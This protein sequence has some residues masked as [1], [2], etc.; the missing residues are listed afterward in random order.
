MCSWTSSQD[1]ADS[2]RDGLFSLYWLIVW[3]L[4][5]NLWS[6]LY[7]HINRLFD[8]QCTVCWVN[9]AH[10]FHVHWFT[11]WLSTKSMVLCL[12]VCMHINRWFVRQ[13]ERWAVLQF[14][15]PADRW[16]QVVRLCGQGALP[17][18]RPPKYTHWLCVVVRQS[19]R[20]S[21]LLLEFANVF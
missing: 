15:W 20:L 10:F 13:L 14:T 21:V 5:I 9:D 1:L 12:C 17:G 18:T 2:S 11:D 8:W 19:S 6:Y 3:F 4:L 16:V 7:M